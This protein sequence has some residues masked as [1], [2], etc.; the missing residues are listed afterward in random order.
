VWLLRLGVTVI[1]GRPYHPQT[2]GKDER[3]HRTLKAD[4]LD[5]HDWKD[6]PQTQRRFDQYRRLY[7]HDRPHEAI[8]L[9]VPATR[10]RPSS[11][12]LPPTL[13]PVEYD[14][15]ELVRTV[16]SKGEITFRN[17]FYYVG[18]AFVGLPLA[19]RPAATDGV[20]RVCL[21]AFTLGVIDCAQPSSRPKGSYHRLEFP[22]S[23]VLPS[24]R[25]TCYP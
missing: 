22:T 3:F 7:N 13:P 5:R 18:Q 17:R 6:L 8:G 15:L 9:A 11:R 1:H 14:P 25:D 2:Q 10:Y 4:L 12:Q 21:C 16:K 20:F 19:L 23:K 24:T